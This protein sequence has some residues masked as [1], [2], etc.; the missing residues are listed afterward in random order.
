MNNF[1]VHA[2]EQVLRFTSVNN[3]S[4]L[5]EERKIQ[6]SFNMGVVSLGLNLTKQEGY[7][8]IASAGRGDISMSELHQH[9]RSLIVSNSVMVDEKNVTKTF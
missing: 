5:S 3:W 4:D 6:L 9:L 1:V 2:C 7:D 8:S